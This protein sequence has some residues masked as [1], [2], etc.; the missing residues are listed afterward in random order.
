MT[1]AYAVRPS[2]V[3]AIQSS[4]EFSASPLREDFQEMVIGLRQGEFE[5]SAAG[6]FGQARQH[7]V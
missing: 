5:E 2:L 3:R 1:N 6:A 4:A 7:R